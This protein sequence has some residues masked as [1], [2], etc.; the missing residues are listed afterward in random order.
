M[1]KSNSTKKSGRSKSATGAEKSRASGKKSRAQSAADIPAKDAE[2]FTR[3][4]I[5]RGEAAE[6]DAKG[7]LSS[8][9]THEIVGYDPDGTPR[10]KRRR[11]SIS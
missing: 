6:A 3:G 10:L 1:T 11:Y 5:I 9:T 8:E 7:E 2:A 4:V